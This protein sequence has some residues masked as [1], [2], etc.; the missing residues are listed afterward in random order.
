MCARLDA[1]YGVS[2]RS[3]APISE[4]RYDALE[5]SVV[6]C[7]RAAHAAVVAAFAWAFPQVSLIIYEAGFG[8]NCAGS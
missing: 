4:Q 3:R 5:N 8:T 7:V 1:C 6:A 2:G